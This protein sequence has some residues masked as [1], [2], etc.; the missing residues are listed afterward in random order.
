MLSDREKQLAE[1]LGKNPHFF[2]FMELVKDRV[3]DVRNGNAPPEV[4]K[5]VLEAIEDFAISP[6]RVHSGR[7][8]VENNETFV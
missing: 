2:E 8:P 5:G 6:C 3:A 7:E 4:R 1:S